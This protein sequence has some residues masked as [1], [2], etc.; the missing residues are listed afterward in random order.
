[1]LH[2]YGQAQPWVLLADTPVAETEPTLYAC[3]NWIEQGFRGLKTVGWKWHKTRRLDPTQRVPGVGRHWLVLAI[4][5]LLAVAYGTRREEAE[6]R[7]LNLPAPPARDPHR[8]PPSLSPHPG[9]LGPQHHAARHTGISAP[10]EHSRPQRVPARCPRRA[11]SCHTRGRPPFRTPP[12]IPAREIPLS[13]CLDPTRVGRHWLVLALATLLAVAY[14]TRREEAAARH[15]APGR[16]LLRGYL[17]A[18]ARPRLPRAPTLGGPRRHLNLPAPSARD[19]HCTPP[20]LSPRP[21]HLGPPH[22]GPPHAGRAHRSGC[23]YRFPPRK[24]PCQQR[25][26][27]P[28]QFQ[29]VQKDLS[30]PDQLGAEILQRTLSRTLGPRQRDRPRAGSPLGASRPSLPGARTVAR[31]QTEHLSRSE[32]PNRGRSLPVVGPSLAGLVRILTP[33]TPS[34]ETR[35][36]GRWAPCRAEDSRASG[37][38]RRSCDTP[39]DRC[40]VRPARAVATGRSP[41]DCRAGPGGSG[42]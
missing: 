37:P 14:G 9:R 1:M 23:H 39:V 28:R 32:C 2:A 29:A 24:Y 18:H 20:S 33:V 13:S 26:P 36:A 12:P 42:P 5:T 7:H 27:H 35:K 38:G 6:A 10:L 19:H 16:L 34:T 41:G 25:A 4:A 15:L 22:R 30:H 31:I 3:R 11:R 21:G 8:T 40:T 17:W